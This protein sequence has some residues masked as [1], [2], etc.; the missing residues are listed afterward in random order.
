LKEIKLR[1]AIEKRMLVPRLHPILNHTVFKYA[2]SVRP[3]AACGCPT[4]PAPEATI[5][6]GN[7][8]C[9][10]RDPACRVD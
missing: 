4:F 9:P 1:L 7:T 8:M 10:G 2:G 3:I 5:A 6:T